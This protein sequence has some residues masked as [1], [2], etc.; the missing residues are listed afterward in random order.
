MSPIIE[1][2][3]IETSWI[4]KLPWAKGHFRAY[5]PFFPSAIES[6]DLRGYDLIISTSHCVA[7]G[8]VPAAHALHISYLHTP[9]RYIW[10]MYPH[11]L[12]KKAGWPKRVAGAALASYLRR[13]DVS[14]CRRVHH[15][16]AN[17]QNVRRRIREHYG[18]EAEVIPP[19]V[20]GEFF[21][22]TREAD[23]YFLIVTA[24]VPYKQISL[25][26]Q[27]FNSLGMRLVIVGDGPEKRSLQAMAGPN[28]EFLPWQSSENLRDL[29]SG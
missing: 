25:A 15:F 27:A 28:I 2:M 22:P 6:F 20:D 10:E 3:R 1:A 4:M 11:Y 19:P 9:M 7:K 23:D 13:W 5:L 12:G 21:Y 17:S 8:A 24:L 29:Y 14:S 16:V 26:V 18:R